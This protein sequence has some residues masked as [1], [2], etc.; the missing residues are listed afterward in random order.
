MYIETVRNYIRTRKLQKPTTEIIVHITISRQPHVTPRCLE[1]RYIRVLHGEA[2]FFP[3]YR[4]SRSGIIP[5]PFPALRL[6]FAGA[7]TGL[8]KRHDGLGELRVVFE[9]ALVLGGR[10]GRELSAR[11]GRPHEGARRGHGVVSWSPAT[12]STGTSMVASVVVAS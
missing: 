8:A 7:Q 9:Q 6:L 11:N 1:K 12:S 2:D 3:T 10:Q 5:C 4:A